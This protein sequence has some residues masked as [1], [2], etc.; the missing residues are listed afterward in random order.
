M[1]P[2]M[3]G[4]PASKAGATPQT[5][6]C[7]GCAVKPGAYHTTWCDY[8][9]GHGELLY[10]IAN[11]SVVDEC[12]NCG[13]ATELHQDGA[14]PKVCAECGNAMHE[15]PED[16]SINHA[17]HCSLYPT[18]V[19]CPECSYTI[20]GDDATAPHNAHSV[21]CSYYVELPNTKAQWIEDGMEGDCPD[22]HSP[23]GF[24][25]DDGNCGGDPNEV[26]SAN[27][28]ELAIYPPDTNQGPHAQASTSWELWL[29]RHGHAY[30]GLC[31]VGHP[32]KAD[33]LK[34]A[35]HTLRDLLAQLESA[36]KAHLA[37]ED[38]L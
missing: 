31:I 9:A 38:T 7:P 22:C 37:L 16:V 11:M 6:S 24:H 30:S 15:D 8:A 34:G 27:G 36:T 23:S 10:T 4:Y 35:I 14:C 12:P 5:P 33:T 17:K 19:D 1:K 13:Y 2:I 3:K 32:S 29:N 28:L 20:P 21:E 18:A 25:D 26:A